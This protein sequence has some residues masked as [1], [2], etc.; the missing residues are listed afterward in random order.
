MFLGGG[1]AFEALFTFLVR[2]PVAL[3]AVL[4]PPLLVRGVAGAGVP[5]FCVLPGV[6]LGRLEGRGVDVVGPVETR[7]VRGVDGLVPTPW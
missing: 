2:T 3:P 1:I 4:K 7:P 5:L 6:V